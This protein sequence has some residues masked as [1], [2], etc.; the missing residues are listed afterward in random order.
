MGGAERRGDETEW[1]L[2]ACAQRIKSNFI[3]R[4]SLWHFGGSRL[5][6]FSDATL[7]VK[8]RGSAMLGTTLRLETTAVVYGFAE[9]SVIVV[10][11]YVSLYRATVVWRHTCGRLRRPSPTRPSWLHV[12]LQLPLVSYAHR[13]QGAEY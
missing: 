3:F 12:I 8:R 4:I 10:E 7:E 5:C 11:E 6:A 9:R 13:D 2:K 1:G